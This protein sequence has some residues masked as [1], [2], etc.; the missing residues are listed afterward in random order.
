[1]TDDISRWLQAHSTFDPRA[2][3]LDWDWEQ[4]FSGLDPD[5]FAVALRRF[6]TE[7]DGKAAALALEAITDVAWWVAEIRG[8]VHARP[9]VAGLAAWLEAFTDAVLDDPGFVRGCA[10]AYVPPLP[11][12]EQH[13]VDAI[14][15]ARLRELGTSNVTDACA[16]AEEVAAALEERGSVAAAERIWWSVLGGTVGS[17]SRLVRYA[18][19]A[20]FH[21]AD[22]R[23]RPAVVA[24]RAALVDAVTA[25]LQTSGLPFW[26]RVW[27]VEP[28]ARVD[29]HL[30][31]DQIAQ[32]QMPW[33]A[34]HMRYQLQLS[35]DERRA[36]WNTWTAAP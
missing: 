17:A 10:L 13:F 20:A 33:L 28:V 4:T 9:P 36:R 1:M 25:P 11:L 35:A 12:G 24:L 23:R 15:D 30:L 26:A 29:R 19:I 22:R 6:A 8:D 3:R 5:R 14:V 27:L 34:D 32:E 16:L 2:R 21:Q 31:E 7:A 18:E